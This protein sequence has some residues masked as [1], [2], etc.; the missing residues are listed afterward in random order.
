MA[1]FCVLLPIHRP[2]AFLPYAIRS[3][4]AQEQEDFELYVI[5]DGA[6]QETGEC[7]LDFARED[8]RIKV[9][10]HPKGERHGEAYRHQVLEK[11]ASTYVCQ[12]AD[13]D[14]WFPDHL[15]EMER[16]LKNAD[17]GHLPQVYVEISGSL[18]IRAS[19]LADEKQ[20]TRMRAEKFNTFGP[21]EC[22]YRLSA[23][24]N[25]TQG[26]SPAPDGIWTDLHMWRKFLAAPGLRFATRYTVTSLH[27][28]ASPRKETSAQQRAGEI[29]L[30][31][32]RVQTAEERD[33]IVQEALGM[34]ATDALQKR[35]L[36]TQVRQL[37]DKVRQLA[38][39]A[40]YYRLS[41]VWNVVEVVRRAIRRLRGKQQPAFF[42]ESAGK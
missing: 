6:P 37:T 4:Q 2:P 26:W 40:D 22:G 36:D 27:F 41:R 18:R 17:F 16:L 31:L 8:A 30:W 35:F 38:R 34:L 11:S 24:R 7:A 9:R 25:L 14:I 5:C 28:P 32:D 3:V 42:D 1:L 19:N 20:R 33:R 10:I 13:D 15:A 23:Y 39:I 12:I 29:E 21:T